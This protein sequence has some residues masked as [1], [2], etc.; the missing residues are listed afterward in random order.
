M[1]INPDPYAVNGLV[2]TLHVFLMIYITKTVFLSL[3]FLWSLHC[4]SPHYSDLA[5]H[6]ALID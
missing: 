2:W 6:K 1:R 4:L 3:Q 5:E